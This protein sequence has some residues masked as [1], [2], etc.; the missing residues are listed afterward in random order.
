M[1]EEIELQQNKRAIT[2]MMACHP[3]NQGGDRERKKK[4]KFSTL[5]H[6]MANIRK[7]GKPEFEFC[8]EQ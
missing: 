7:D 5:G 6:I 4:V 3:G 2:Y 1:D 8:F